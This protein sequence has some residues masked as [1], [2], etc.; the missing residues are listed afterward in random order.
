MNRNKILKF[1]Y[2]L[3][4]VSVFVISNVTLSV[5]ATKE[6]I[7]DK[8]GKIDEK[9]N[10]TNSEI[11]VVKG[12]ISSTMAEVQELS[13]Q[14]SAY[15]SEI[16]ELESQ[17]EDLNSEIE[18]TEKNLKEQEEK[19]N[20]Q[21][22]LLQK[23]LVAL[24]EAG[25]T[26]YL[27][28]LLS[29]DGLTQFIS[30]YY[31]ISTLAECDTDLLKSIETLKNEIAQTKV[32]LEEK[33]ATVENSKN[34]IEAKSSALAVIKN[35]KTS[36]VSKLNAS[37]KELQDQLDQFEK[38][39]QDLERELAAI[40]AAEEAANRRYDEDISSNPSSSGY[41]SPL[42]GRTKNNITT[43]YRGYSTHTGVDFAVSSGTPI[44]AV[45][46][47]T[48]EISKALYDA[49][50]N[51]RSYGEYIVINHHDGTM[52]L[53]AHGSP[54]SRTVS[55]GQSVAQG[56]TIMLVGTT[57]NSTGP[58]LHFEVRVNARPVNPTPYLP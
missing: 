18:V 22:D 17:I 53:Y 10:A 2:V 11:R 16:A 21:Q 36:K 35:D 42:A 29:S 30:N 15:E 45:K 41:I 46:S 55:P 3:I 20:V 32:S 47:G 26:T 33:K 27:D 23:R 31:L 6:E 58:H 19:Y 51:Y 4:I 54:G 34:T 44:R 12:E 43:G 37:E 5:A 39:K 57:G 25:S 38:D 52:T 14:I 40:L 28:M 48:V 56:E 1:A 9:I 49:N 50:G 13:N 24:Y 8:E 7:K